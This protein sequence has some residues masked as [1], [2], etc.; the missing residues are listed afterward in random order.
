MTSQPVSSVQCF[1]SFFV[2]RCPVGLGELQPVY[3]L[4]LSSHLFFFPWPMTLNKRLPLNHGFGDSFGLMCDTSV[5]IVEQE[6]AKLL[7]TTSLNWKKRLWIKYFIYGFPD[8][9]HTVTT[10]QSMYLL[11]SFSV[12]LQSL[13]SAADNDNCAKRGLALGSNERTRLT[14][15]KTTAN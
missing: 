3:S 4:M 1:P 12:F 14:G 7:N 11:Q 13:C 2:L 10:I 6:S 15:H 5:K 8:L 9:M